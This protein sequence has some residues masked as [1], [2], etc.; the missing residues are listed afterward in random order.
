MSKEEEIITKLEF[1]RSL[2]FIGKKPSTYWEETIRL[3]GRNSKS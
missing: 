1:R 3:L 2:W